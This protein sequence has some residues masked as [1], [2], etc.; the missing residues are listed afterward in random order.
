MSTLISNGFTGVTYTAGDTLTVCFDLTALTL[1]WLKNGVNM[2]Y[3]MN[4]PAGKTWFPALSI[5]TDGKVTYRP[6]GLTYLPVGFTEW[7]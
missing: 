4:L 3:T 7:G 2:G 1:E 6:A 5:Q